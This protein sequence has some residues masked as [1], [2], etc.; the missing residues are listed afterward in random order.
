MLWWLFAC[1]P[2][3]FPP[4]LV[5]AE[6]G[7]AGY[8]P[9]NSAYAVSRALDAGVDGIELDL[10]LTDDGVVLVRTA[11]RLDDTCTGP[12]DNGDRAL[13]RYTADALTAWTCG[14][15]PDPAW[16]NA[17]VRAEPIPRF[18]DL[19][20]D[21]VARAPATMPLELTLAGG[22]PQAIAQAVLDV[23]QAVDPPNPVA[24]ASDDPR[25]LDAIALEGTL[26]G[27][28]IYT[29]SV[30]AA[31]PLPADLL[32]AGVVLP[33]AD[34]VALPWEAARRWEV[35]R[36]WDEGVPVT[37]L[38]A[39]TPEAIAAHLGWP[40]EAIRTGYPGDAP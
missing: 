32:G 4:P 31:P 33:E 9:A 40:L 8:W 36:L 10:G 1:R 37:L 20:A 26:R 3:A 15:L 19:L 25:H 22:P 12:H 13:K 35:V 24:F 27:M 21:L 28:A 30:Q 34:G 5:L 39:D 7:G 6:D 16:P 23:W 38:G 18:D 14:G 11:A 17:E 2:V 29:V